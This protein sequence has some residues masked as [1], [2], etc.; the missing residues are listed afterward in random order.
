VDSSH[1]YRPPSAG[2]QDV[3]AASARERTGA[4][5]L[6]M[7]VKAPGLR[8][9]TRRGCSTAPHKWRLH[10]RNSRRMQRV[11][12]AVNWMRA[13]PR[14]LPRP[15]TSC[16]LQ[17]HPPSPR[18]LSDQP[19]YATKLH[20]SLQLHQPANSS[21]KPVRASRAASRGVYA[22]AGHAVGQERAGER[23]RSFDTPQ[24]HM[25]HLHRPPAEVQLRVM[26]G[27]R[28]PRLAS[29]L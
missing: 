6:S 16:P 27:R 3:G 20:A 23:R 17:H 24:P 22:A 29:R 11:P 10:A 28:N 25:P 5:A 19:A 21:A 15:P 1:S 26:G 13:E 12:A 2:Y 4:R 14:P 8:R 9:P 7:T 18:R